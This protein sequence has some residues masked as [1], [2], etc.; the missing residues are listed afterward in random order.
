MKDPAFLF[1]S[2]DFYEGTR[3]MLP[4]ECACYVDLLIYQH[5]NGIIPNDPKRLQMYCSGCSLETIERVLKDKFNQMVDGWLNER[6]SN[7]KI[8]RSENRPK[9]IASATLAGLIS[10]SNLTKKKA[11]EI[12]KAFEIEQFIY[13]DKKELEEVENIKLNIR[14][15]FNHLVDH[16]VN[17][18]ANANANANEDKN[19]IKNENNTLVRKTYER[20]IEFFPKDL[21]PKNEN[22][23]L[24]T[25]KDLISID[26]QNPD[27]II[28]VIKQTRKDPFWAKN[29]LSIPK[30]R[31]NNKD[32]VKY[33]FVFAENINAKKLKSN[34]RIEAYA[35]GWDG[36][37]PQS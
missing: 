31:K 28:E 11:L 16:T 36:V 6:L 8:S 37:P 3:M 35:S 15:W 29:F 1:Y 14:K 26:E 17:N 33:F 27:V 19:I 34:E 18:I 2:K 22:T 5:Q 20:A 30:L 12:K 7:E 13:N 10:S 25:I 32:G 23:W 4:E 24:K 21:I 9:K